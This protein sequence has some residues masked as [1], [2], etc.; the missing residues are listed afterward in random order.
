M[1]VELMWYDGTTD[2][3][4]DNL[5]W[6]DGTND[7]TFGEE[8]DGRQRIPRDYRVSGAA[9]GSG[10]SRYYVLTPYIPQ[11]VVGSLFRVCTGYAMRVETASGSSLRSGAVR[12]NIPSTLGTITD[13]NFTLIDYILRL[14]ILQVQE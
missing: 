6:F 10:A 1:A 11:R 12:S 8:L 9:R 14:L 13:I 7:F 5:Q 4:A 3:V 2:K